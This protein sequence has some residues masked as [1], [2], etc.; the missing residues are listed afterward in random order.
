MAMPVLSLSSELPLVVHRARSF[1]GRLGGLLTR[2]ELRKGEGLYLAPCASVHTLFMVYDIDVVFL[3]RGGRVLHVVH[4]LGPWRAASC[5]GAYAALELRAG[6]ARR[7]G[8]V[9]GISLSTVVGWDSEEGI[10]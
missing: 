7:Y 3:D 5:R 1:L 2:S 4:G 8:V 9:R 6:Q 10:A